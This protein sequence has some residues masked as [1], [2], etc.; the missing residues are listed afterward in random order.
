MMSEITVDF[1][2]FSNGTVA[3]FRNGLILGR[4]KSI[5]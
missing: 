4:S 2:R 3:V 5:L 1:L